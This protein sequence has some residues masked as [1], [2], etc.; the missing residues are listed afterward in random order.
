MTSW[1]WVD[2]ESRVPSRFQAQSQ[3]PEVAGHGR[4]E[5]TEINLIPL[6][7]STFPAAMRGATAMVKDPR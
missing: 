1:R 3:A 6:R 5:M 4:V 7:S 2:F